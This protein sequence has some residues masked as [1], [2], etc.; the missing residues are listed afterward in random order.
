MADLLI[1]DIGELVTCRS[2]DTGRRGE[3]ALNQ[4]DL[5]RN[6]A[7][8][9]RNGRILD[10][11][12]NAELKQRYGA[13]ETLSAEGRVV[14]PGLVDC[15]AH[16]LYGGSRH[17]EY[18]AQLKDAATGQASLGGGIRTSV[19]HTRGASE[20]Q[21]RLQA[22]NDLDIMLEH[23]TTT[24]E[25]K[26]GYGLDR[27]T[28]LRLLK[29]QA[30]LEHEV[31]LVRTYLGAHV[32]PSEFL[33]DREAYVQLVIDMLPAASEYAEYCDVC[34]DPAGF[35]YDECMRIGTRA[36]ELGMRIKVHAD[37]T[38]PAR[39]VELGV[40]LG[41]TSVD[42]LDYVSD[43]GMDLLANSDTTGVLFPAVTLH[44][45][46]MVPRLVN[47]R[48]VGP[49]KGFMPEVCRRLIQHDALLAISSDYN[50]G[51]APSPSLQATMQLAARLYQLSYAEIWHM[52]TI[53][54]AHALDRAAD[55]G[56]IEVGKRADLVIWDVR[57]H[58]MVIHR[59][60][61]NLADTVVK[62]G[63]VVTLGGKRLARPDEG[64]RIP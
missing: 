53:N 34:C 55:I 31:D 7:V 17:T 36:R 19:D 51:S 49:S 61:V 15:H 50:P 16:L 14:S 52:S 29:L 21:L 20:Q 2:P 23:G 39:G 8:A 62:N 56:S 35:T 42:H 58:G 24:L 25:V 9:V 59:F 28:E 46:E 44:L 48:W 43:D 64:S 12:A 30:S 60:G 47:G 33:E 4:L 27:D 40:R 1:C 13:M 41:A 37:Q 6:A 10:V 26:T 32:V 38:G 22:E 45:R 3:Q 5:V 57:H 63:H 11:G 18:E 54:A